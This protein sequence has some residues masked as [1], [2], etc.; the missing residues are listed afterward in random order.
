M[1]CVRWGTTGRGL[2]AEEFQD[3]ILVILTYLWPS[4]VS[5]KAKN[6]VGVRFQ[7]VANHST[8]EYG[9][10]SACTIFLRSM[11]TQDHRYD[12]RFPGISLGKVSS[13]PTCQL[14]FRAEKL[15]SLGRL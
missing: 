9:V 10:S 15:L 8:A 2:L 11:A 14:D 3:G 13:Q 7:V 1:G 12:G 6:K 5:Q 4:S